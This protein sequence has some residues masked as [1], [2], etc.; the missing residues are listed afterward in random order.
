MF[1]LTDLEGEV[2]NGAIC[3]LKT[4]LR[5]LLELCMSPKGYENEKIMNI[6]NKAAYGVS[7]E[8]VRQVSS[9]NSWVSQESM[10]S[11]KCI[12]ILQNRTVSDVMDPHKDVLT[13]GASL[14]TSIS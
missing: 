7:H 5:S 1:V 3:V 14:K 2:P 8:L 11:L 6:K 13:E 12:A 9:S 4:I 10:I